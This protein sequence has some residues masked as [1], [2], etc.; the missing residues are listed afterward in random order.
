MNSTQ[1]HDLREFNEALLVSSVHQHELAELA[2]QAEAALR[3]SNARFEAI[4][5]T[6]PV[7]MYL[8]D[9]ELRIRQMSLKA[10][11]IFGNIAELIG[12]DFVEVMHIMW[13]PE[14]ADE[15]VARFRHTLAT[16]ETY[17][18]PDFSAVRYD[19]QV[20]EYYDW[21]IH[22]IALPNEQF[23]AVCYFTDTS[24]RV[25]AEAARPPKTAS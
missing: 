24:A 23:G 8:V 10:R 7:G 22:R 16:G 4:V 21:Q 6:S 2:Q 20:R 14:V 1:E 12:S 13:P 15:I 18:V 11:P 19:R 3:A 25:L 9:A 17:A 5:D